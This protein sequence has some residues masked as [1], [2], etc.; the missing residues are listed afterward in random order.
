M[1]SWPLWLAGIMA[2]VGVGLYSV[3]V[4]H[5]FQRG[6]AAVGESLGEPESPFVVQC[7]ETGVVLLLLSGLF[8]LALPS[9]RQAR[10]GPVAGLGLPLSV[11]AA[12]G[13]L[14]FNLGPPAFLVS[15]MLGVPYL[16]TAVAASLVPPDGNRPGLL[17]FALARW[18]TVGTF[19]AIGLVAIGVLGLLERGMPQVPWAS[20]LAASAIGTVLQVSARHLARHGGRPEA[21]AQ[22]HRQVRRATSTADIDDVAARLH[23]FIEEGRD[24]AAY[25]ALAGRLATANRA[26]APEA[27]TDAHPGAPFPFALG[28]LAAILGTA[29]A[30][31]PAWLVIPPPVQTGAT[32]VVA[33]LALPW[34]RGRLAPRQEPLA[35][36]WWLV[37]ASLLAAGGFLLTPV[38]VDDAHAPW[39]TLL[40]APDLVLAVAV[41]VRRRPEG[42]AFLRSQHADRMGRRSRRALL[43]A[44]A[45]A[46][47]SILLPPFLLA[48]GFLLGLDAPDIPLPF[49]AAGVAA[50]V[51]GGL[52]I[53]VAGP[54][55]NAYRTT[56]RLRLDAA[57][58]ERLERHRLILQTLETT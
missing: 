34:A 46:A 40:G 26:A 48:A 31:V 32:L 43:R 42:L 36:G 54:G 45:I 22:A 5:V 51:L 29:A 53:L 15:A 38:L 52:A 49:V 35:A 20:L 27:A 3:F 47:V 25:T 12:S 6:D 9:V 17:R 16:V 21:V 56:A 10:W 8:A 19:L 30:A 24:A 4:V 44:L 18:M 41:L 13:V 33:G 39:G 23:P 7:G 57:R 58:E 50:G 55:A 28:A 14:A 11:A 1:K 2:L 37:A